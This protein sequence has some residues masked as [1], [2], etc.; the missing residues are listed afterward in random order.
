MQRSSS[1]WRTTD[2]GWRYDVFPLDVDAAATGEYASIAALWQSKLNGPR[3]PAW[4][5]FDLMDFREWWG[6]L[7]VYDVV[8]RDPLDLWCRLWGTNLVRFHGLEVTG[9]NLSDPDAG[10]YGDSSMFDDDDVEF[11]DYLIDEGMIGLCRGAMTWQEREHMR[12]SALRLP[13]ADDGARVDRILGVSQYY[14]D[15]RGGPE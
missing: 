13:L 1:H 10:M 15:D 12:V 7:A 8:R 2:D 9:A 6:Y 14:L 3:L 4:R 11:F 5:D